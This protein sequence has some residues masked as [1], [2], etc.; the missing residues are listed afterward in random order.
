MFFLLAGSLQLWL[1]GDKTLCALVRE[2]DV[3][4]EALLVYVCRCFC[5]CE[6]NAEAGLCN[7]I[8]SI[9]HYI[10]YAVLNIIL[11]MQY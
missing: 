10:I 9:K 7:D 3:T 5:F 1:C 11:F 4:E 2:L 6:E 8:S